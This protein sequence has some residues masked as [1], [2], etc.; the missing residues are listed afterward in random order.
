MTSTLEK[1]GSILGQEQ[2][3]NL[4]SLDL[5][6]VKNIFWLCLYLLVQILHHVYSQHNLGLIYIQGV[7]VKVIHYLSLSSEY[8]NPPNYNLCLI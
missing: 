4:N 3:V 8:R 6:Q 5:L 2:I 1:L 7:F